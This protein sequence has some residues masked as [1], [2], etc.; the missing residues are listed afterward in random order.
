MVITRL[1]P[2][3]LDDFF[4]LLDGCAGTLWYHLPDQFTETWT[5]I[6]KMESLASDD[7][8]A[9][10]GWDSNWWQV[11]RLITIMVRTLQ[12]LLGLKPA[13]SPLTNTRRTQ[14]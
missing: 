2:R 4:V 7:V 5:N 13:Q 12:F 3:Y 6:D 8:A 10:Y 11:G 9:E 14:R 1:L